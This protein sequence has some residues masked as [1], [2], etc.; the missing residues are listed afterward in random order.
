ML[1]KKIQDAINEQINSEFYS[2]YLYL[3]MSAYCEPANMKGFA[4]WMMLQ[5]KEEWGHGM[6]FFDYVSDRGGRVMLR[7]ID[8]PPAEFKSP[9]D[10]FQK[11][12][13][14]EQEVTAKIHR[15]YELAVKEDDYA[16]QVALQ[17]FITEQV[18]EEKN[19][20]EIVDQLKMIGDHKPSLMMLDK[21]LGA[22]Q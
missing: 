22:R 8:K 10:V 13:S 17:W 21:Q 15:L 7:T 9:L 1:S 16:T 11:V 2:S 6:K 12:L 5:S 20:G 19:A 4:H 14:H 3:S 18:E